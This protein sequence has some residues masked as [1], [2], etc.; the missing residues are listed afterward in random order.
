MNKAKEKKRQILIQAI[1]MLGIIVFANIIC[2]IYYKRIDLTGDKRY[3]L[4]E[5]T[6]KLLKNTKDIVYVKVYLEGKNL[7]AGFRRLHDATRDIL[8][9]FRMIAGD[10][11]Q[12]QFINPEDIGDKEKKKKLYHQL[13]SLGLNAVNLQQNK[14]DEFSQQIIFPGAI[15][16]YNNESMS[17]T[18]LEQQMGNMSSD[19]IL[20]NSI[21]QIEY[22]FANTLRKLQSAVKP[23]IAFVQGHGELQPRFVKDIA[24]ALSEYYTI[25]FVN[26]P[27]YKVGRYD[28]YAAL[29]VAKPDSTF[30]EL[31][32]YKL[33]QYV[34]KGGKILF[35]IDAL[36]AEFDS[37][38]RSGSE[39]TT[40]YPLH[41]DDLFYKYGVRINEELV[42]DLNCHYI[43][44]ITSA[45]GSQNRES[46]LK[47]PFYP[48]VTPVGDHP[49]VNGLG[50]IWFQFANTID[51]VNTR[52]TGNLKFSTL[53]QTSART[54][55]FTN[56]AMVSL[57]MAGDKDS[58][59][60]TRGKKNLAI[61]AEGNFTSL[62]ANDESPGPEY[63]EMLRKSAPA[64][65]LVISDGNVI[66]NQF[67]IS[68][69]KAYPL[70]YDLWTNTWF[71]NKKFIL[72]CV[73]YLVKN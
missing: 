32:K 41:L 11:I 38:A 37:L 21:T 15:I 19:E 6:I 57:D 23:K 29:I 42:L 45:Y 51:I 55:T 8:D 2:N 48:L 65:I 50:G 58:I 60:Y 54:K 35:C 70:G 67:I 1:L 26:S 59:H 68:A 33:D 13:A 25:D 4:S 20:N 66:K 3:T 27:K 34:M 43:P 39:L 10:R 14:E 12:Y 47:W 24:D 40:S 49:I 30:T 52:N 16:T 56:P 7:P 73:D 61:L 31:E 71:D 53:L 64:K 17:T 63:G 36:S 18:L 9:E 46:V 22:H 5:P 44:L 28:D 69:K 62:F 72:N